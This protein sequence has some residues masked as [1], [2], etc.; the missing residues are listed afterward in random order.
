VY[1]TIAN[2]I[3]PDIYTIIKERNGWGQLK[4][5]RNAWI[6]LS[7]VEPVTGPG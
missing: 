7:A 5:Y 6:L 2:I 3:E 4:E 1:P